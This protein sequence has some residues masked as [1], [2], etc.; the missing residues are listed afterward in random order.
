MDAEILKYVFTQTVFG[1]LFFWLLL[2][3]QKKNTDR[4]KRSEERESSYQSIIKELTMKLEIISSIKT[5]IDK[6]EDKVEEILH[7]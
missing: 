3:T 5:Q 2:D 4:E 7:K 6:V 1:G